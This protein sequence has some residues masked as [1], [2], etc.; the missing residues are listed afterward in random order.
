VCVCVC[1]C[2]CVCS[3]LCV[4]VYVCACVFGVLCG[5]CVYRVSVCGI[6]L[7][8][9]IVLS[10]PLQCSQRTAMH[11]SDLSQPLALNDVVARERER[12]RARER[13]RENL[14]YLT[15]TIRGDYD[16]D[17]EISWISGALSSRRRKGKRGS[18]MSE[19]TEVLKTC[20]DRHENDSLLT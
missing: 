8:C 3:C 5:V 20:R 9:D 7:V 15:A 12:A 11:E 17:G 13:E 14:H 6:V 4:C 2:L 1:V 19:R 18:G 10:L 16:Y